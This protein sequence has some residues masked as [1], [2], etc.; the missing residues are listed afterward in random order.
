VSF[1]LQLLITPLVSSNFSEE[2]WI[3]SVAN[4]LLILS[5]GCRGRVGMVV[6]FLIIYAINAYRH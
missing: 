4:A 2:Q 6:G 1:D 3:S 5:R